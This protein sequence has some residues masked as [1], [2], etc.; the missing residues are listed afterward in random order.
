MEKTLLVTI[1]KI[2]LFVIAVAM[3]VIGVK[4]KILPPI[5]TG[6]GFVLIALAL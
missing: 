6:V 3:I 2:S 5:L 4:A 1:A